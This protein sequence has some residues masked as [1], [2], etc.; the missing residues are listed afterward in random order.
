M[1]RTN[2]LKSLFAL[3]LMIAVLASCNKEELAELENAE[4]TADV[5]MLDRLAGASVKED[6]NTAAGEKEN[7]CFAFNYPITV[8]EP[9]GT[10]TEINDE[11]A[12]DEFLETY[13]RAYEDMEEGDD[14]LDMDITLLYPVEVTLEDGSIEAINNDE[15]LDDLLEDCFEKYEEEYFEDCFE[16]QYPVTVIF[17][18]GTTQIANSDDDLYMIEDTF[19]R[20]DANEEEDLSFVYPVTI[21]WEDGTEEIINNDEELEVAFEACEGHDCDDKDRGDR[22]G[23]HDDDRDERHKDRCFE[24]IFPI[25]IM[26]VD[27]TEETVE[28]RRDL[29]ELVK[30]LEENEEDEEGEDGSE[31][32]EDEKPFSIVFPIEVMLEDEST[33]SI[34]SEEA[35]EVLK[36]SCDD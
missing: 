36:E 19:Y 6:S 10:E 27:G 8:V 4:T 5:N 33:T 11:T 3:V 35:F 30:G 18:D 20:E 14:E 17:P 21:I 16:L 22:G 34:D 28:S 25:N 15:E 12:L 1:I 9:D 26:L 32:D 29:R 13:Y 7:D 23:F 31:E 2:F 24:V